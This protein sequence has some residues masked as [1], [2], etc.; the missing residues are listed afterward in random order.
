[1]IDSSSSSPAVRFSGVRKSFGDTVAV[2]GVSFDVGAGEF[3]SILGPSGCG[4]TTTLRLLAGFERP[5]EGE[6]RL[7]GERIDDRPPWERPLAMV[8]QSYALFPHL[9]VARNVAFG[10][11]RRKLSRSEIDDRVRMVLAL[12][13]LDPSTFAH[14]SPRQLS[15]GQRQRVALARALV[16]EP[17]VLLLDEPLGALDRKLRKGM[18]IELRALNRDLGTT[19][20]SVTHDQEEAL[21]KSDRVAVMA[22]GRIAQ[23]GSPSE[24]YE[25]PRTAFVAGFL[26]EANVFE[27]EGGGLASVRPERM[28]LLRPGEAVPGERTSRPGEVREIVYLGDRVQAVVQ[29]DSGLDVLVSLRDSVRD[30]RAWRRGDPTIVAWRPGDAHLLEEGT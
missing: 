9:S 24:V 6:I 14:R 10:L 28:E 17:P 20:I 18:Q 15:G 27:L 29:L 21:T 26:G 25:R 8:F 3:F 19:F 5:D 4:K 13:Q 23:V 16:L 11:E 2:D 1:L 7:Y 22:D 30:Q 12:V